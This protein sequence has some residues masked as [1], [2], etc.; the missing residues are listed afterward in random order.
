MIGLFLQEPFGFHTNC[1]GLSVFSVFLRSVDDDIINTP[2]APNVGHRGFIF[3]L[4]GFD[5]CGE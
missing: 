2:L 3:V 5:A 4:P 1:G